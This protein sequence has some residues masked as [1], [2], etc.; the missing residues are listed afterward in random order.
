MI[1]RLGPQVIAERRRIYKGVSPNVDFYS[2]FVYSMLDTPARAL[3]ADLRH[4]AHRGLERTY[5]RR[6]DECRQDHRPRIQ[7]RFR[8]KAVCAACRAVSAGRYTAKRNGPSEKPKSVFALIFCILSDPRELP[9]PEK[10]PPPPEKPP[11]AAGKSSAAGEPA[12]VIAAV[13][14][15]AIEAAA[16][17]AVPM[18]A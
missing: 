9:P 1:A 6:I 14:A 18:P 12:A 10:P 7:K 3:H 2:G 13:K 8:R 11:P 17:A 4:G 16:S 15:A 5:A